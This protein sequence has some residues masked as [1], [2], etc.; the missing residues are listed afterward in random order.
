MAWTNDQLKAINISGRNILTSAGA[1]SGK[2]AVLTERVIEKVK[3]GISVD[4]LLILTFTHLAA[5]EMKNRIRAALKKYPEFKEEVN[6]LDSCYITT[7]DSFSLSI[8][9]KY[10]YV[11]NINRDISICHQSLISSYVLKCIDEIFEEMY[12]E[13]NEDFLNMIYSLCMKDDRKVKS[14]IF[15]TYTKKFGSLIDI[16]KFLMNELEKQNSKD[17]VLF[18][19]NQY[20]IL[21]N[22]KIKELI[23]MVEE[24]EKYADPNFETIADFKDILFNESIEKIRN[25]LNDFKA[26]FPNKNKNC[27]ELYSTL[28]TKLKGEVEMVSELLA[29]QQ[30]S[31]FQND[32]DKIKT[33]RNIIIKIFLRLNEKV[34]IYKRNNDLYDF[35]DIARLA[36]KLVKEN[37]SIKEE[38]QKSFQEIMVDEYQDTSDVQEEL[39]SL[40]SN[41]N[42]Y[43]VGDVKQSIYRFRNAN[44]ILFMNKY[45]TYKD[46]NSSYKDGESIKIDLK[47][48]F[49]SRNNVIRAI[50]SI[51]SSIMTDSFGGANY[52]K[53]HKM[54][55]G[56]KGYDALVSD[57][58]DMEVLNYHMLS[59][60]DYEKV[61]KEAFII[62]KDIKEKIKDGFMVF[63]KKN[64]TFRKVNYSD[65][66][67]LISK[68]TDFNIFKK[69]FEYENIPL[70]LYKSESLLSGYNLIIIKNLLKFIIKS[71]NKDFDDEFKH[72]Y[73]SLSR[74]Y[75]FEKNDNAIFETIT[76]NKILE[77]QLYKTCEKLISKIDILNNVSFLESVID[78]FDLIKKSFKAKEI[79][80][81]LSD[82]SSLSS[83]AESLNGVNLYIS[84]LVDLIDCIINNQLELNY[85]IFID[86]TSSVKLMT[87][88][89]SK[90]LEFPICY[91]PCLYSEFNSMDSKSMF[92]FDNELGFIVPYFDKGIRKTFLNTLFVMNSQSQELSEKVRLFYVALTRA[93][94]KIIFLDDIDPE[95]DYSSVSINR[96]KSYREYLQSLYGKITFKITNIESLENITRKYKFFRDKDLEVS[97]DNPIITKKISLSNELLQNNHFSKEV[98]DITFEKIKLMNCGTRMH[99]FLEYYDFDDKE[100]DLGDLNFMF[101]KLTSSSLFEKYIFSKKGKVSIYKE[102]EF[103]YNNCHGIIDLLL[104][105]DDE[106]VIIDYK[107]SN[108]DDKLY[109][110]QVK[111][112]MDYVQN[113]THKNVKGYLYSLSKGVYREVK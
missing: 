69:I 41:N 10:H 39:I 99:E 62:C 65:F 75:L 98:N 58:Y 23:K 71:K 14:F 111:G 70:S 8:V 38:L 93:R 92:S 48:N 89:K 103:M 63:D 109:D 31:D 30:F 55:Y 102:H 64:N 104:E 113:I 37:Q 97:R 3:N 90:G 1:G 35:S 57:C 106:Y 105:Y 91:F 5:L 108:I 85:D 84:D 107:L 27:D 15:N 43:Y 87:I 66:A 68:T 101:S 34:E 77:S 112:Y 28:K 2:T 53:E 36:I 29:Y 72:L 83:L 59:E 4:N 78:E 9:K 19:K 11:L 56:N 40:I 26:Y 16:E 54:E 21:I 44:P 45:N 86:T 20:E 94:E 61:E 18:L 46:S 81:L 12:E 50:N 80:K 88:H 49:R 13:E 60:L 22:D 82:I 42:V 74:S 52:E 32:L 95:K 7:F 110:A 67:I 96:A 33:T 47:M 51:F 100:I 79:D 73:V 24:V 25:S 6:K 76:Q 17:Y